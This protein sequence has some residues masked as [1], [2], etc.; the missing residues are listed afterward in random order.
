MEPKAFKYL[1][2]RQEE[3]DQN[4]ECVADQGESEK[5]RLEEAL[6]NARL[7]RQ[8]VT[9]DM[10]ADVVDVCGGLSNPTRVL[11]PKVAK[12]ARVLDDF[13]Q[14]RLQLKTLEERRIEIKLNSNS[15]SNNS[16]SKCSEESDTTTTVT[17]P[18]AADKE[19]NN[20]DTNEGGK[21]IEAFMNQAKKRIWATVSKLKDVALKMED[22]PPV[23]NGDEECGDLKVK[24][25]SPCCVADV[26]TTTWSC[27]APLCDKNK[28]R[29][30]KGVEV[31][32][33][34]KAEND[35]DGGRILIEAAELYAEVT[36]EGRTAGLDLPKVEVDLA[37]GKPSEA[38]LRLQDLIRILMTKKDEFDREAAIGIS[39]VTE[40][41]KPSNNNSSSN[42]TA[43]NGG[44]K[45]KKEE[46]DD[47]VRIYSSQDTSGKL[48][49]KRI[50]SVADSKKQAKV[51]KYPLAPKFLA[52]TRQK[53]NILYLTKHNLK[54]MARKHGQAF[55][56]GF[57]HNAKTNAAVWPY[58]CSRPTF[59]TAWLYRTA[60]LNSLQAA[61][62]QLRLLWCS[63]RWDDM[64][65]RPL[66]VDGKHQT[67][68]DSAISTTEILKL[69]HTGRFLHKTQYFKRTVTIPLDMPRSSSTSS[70]DSFTPIRSGL[71]KRKRAESP[72]QSE[73]KVTEEWIDEK[74]LELWE[75]RA[76]KVINHCVC[77]YS[78]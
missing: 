59:R 28:N 65:T 19:Q 29:L 18:T 15:S 8:T 22:E 55:A 17:T 14:R 23:A 45:V 73:P 47:I 76:Y 63:V 24:C 11:Y 68:T 56:D 50:Q 7:E 12:K 10:L 39:T 42:S 33:E 64:A 37:F 40:A 3:I 54:H 27:Y 5:K 53:R 48:Y 36:D 62:M 74:K 13:L 69:R 60:S 35:D 67:T 41:S 49:L 32:V 44:D 43:I 75:I 46:K 26:T 58:P 71:R 61:A 52:K 57:N 21:V 16:N 34:V 1:S 25:Y 78:N 9:E 6:K 66:S 51:I 4:K 70:K 72:Q 20:K 38:V 2:A 30:K 77:F 31:K